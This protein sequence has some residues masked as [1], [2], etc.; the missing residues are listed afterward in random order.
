MQYCA[1]S[2]ATPSTA[3]S[4]VITIPDTFYYNCTDDGGI[5][6]INNGGDLSNVIVNYLNQSA[7]TCTTPEKQTDG[8][9]QL[10]NCTM[11]S[12]VDIIL[13]ATNGTDIIGGQ[14]SKTFQIKCETVNI[15]PYY[16]NVTAN[17]TVGGQS[18]PRFVTMATRSTPAPLSTLTMSI[19]DSKNKLVTEAAIG[20][21]LTLAITVPG[22]AT[23]KPT[24]CKAIGNDKDVTLWKEIGCQHD[25]ELFG[26]KWENNGNKTSNTMYGFRFVGQSKSITI[27]CRVR[28]CPAGY[29]GHEC[30]L[31]CI[32]KRKRTNR[33]SDDVTMEQASTSLAITDPLQ[34][35]GA[36]RLGFGL[37]NTI[38][39]VAAAVLVLVNAIF[40]RE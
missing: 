12:T 26:E 10:S 11:N 32:S 36:G 31:T 1:S 25:K 38:T 5:K 2:T 37:G 6:I 20:Q 17:E 9:F 39:F 14:H 35:S 30:D 15:E 4:A 28:V 7:N 33:L 29:N 8:S 23:I 18:T 13:E 3:Q 19:T 21:M 27:T 16:L 22:K 40:T 34:T 24:E